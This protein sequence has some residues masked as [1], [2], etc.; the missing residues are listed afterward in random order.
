MDKV[1]ILFLIGIAAGIIV[2]ITEK[3]YQNSQLFDEPLTAIQ[4]VFAAGT[5]LWHLAISVLIL[6]SLPA[7]IFKTIRNRLSKKQFLPIPF[8]A[9]LSFGFTFMV[10]LGLIVSYFKG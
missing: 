4:R 1:L 5:Q 9:G 3:L 8:V 7:A 10:S 6:I 2:P